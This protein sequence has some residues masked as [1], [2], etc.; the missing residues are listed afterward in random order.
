MKR[1]GF[2]IS[3]V[4]L[5]VVFVSIGSTADIGFKGIGGKVGLVMPGGFADNTVGFGVLVDLGTIIPSLKLEACA[6][7]WS[8]SYSDIASSNVINIG[9]TAKYHFPISK[10]SAFAGGGLVFVVAESGYYGNKIDIPVVGGLTIPIGSSMDFITE[11]RYL[12]NMETFLITG[13]I[14]LKLE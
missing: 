6:D 10:F 9:P 7:Y 12:I 4:F 13:G 1:F 3:F 14:M 2:I 8:R 5:C 11:A